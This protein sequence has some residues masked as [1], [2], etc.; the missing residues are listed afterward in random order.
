MSQR[1]IRPARADDAPRIAEI[2][3]A[4]IA[5]R[6]ATFETEP[7][8]AAQVLAW[9]ES[10]FP[11]FVSGDGPVVMAFALATPYRSRVCYEGVREFSIYVAPEAQGQGHGR[12]ALS[13]LIDDA[14][15][16]GWWKLLS[17]VFPENAGSRALCKSLGFREVGTYERHARLDGRWRDVII[18]ER[19]LG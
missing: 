2:Y 11:L 18:V 14:T 15:K 3:S 16:R 8:Q 12:A 9:L 5:A 17:R 4:G 19:L 1:V 13:M 10:G 6:T 7:R